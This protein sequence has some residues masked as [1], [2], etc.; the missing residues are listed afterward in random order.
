[1]IFWRLNVVIKIA[2]FQFSMREDKISTKKQVFEHFYQRRL[3]NISKGFHK[4]DNTKREKF[5]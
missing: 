5:R 2:T 3:S 1:M 4:Q